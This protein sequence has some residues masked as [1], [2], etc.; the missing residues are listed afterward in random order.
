MKKIILSVLAIAAMAKQQTHN[1]GLV[2]VSDSD[3]IRTL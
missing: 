1:F 3:T 2:V